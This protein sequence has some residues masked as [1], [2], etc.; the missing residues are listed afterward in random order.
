MRVRA[1]ERGQQGRCED[2][3][4]AAEQ[5]AVQVAAAERER[6]NAVILV[7]EPDAFDPEP[8]VAFIPGDP[9]LRPAWAATPQ[10]A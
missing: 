2:Q 10:T 6:A 7:D 3:G 9:S 5:L 8:I 1:G 4:T